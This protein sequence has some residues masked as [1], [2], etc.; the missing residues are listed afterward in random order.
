MLMRRTPIRSRRRFAAVEPFGQH[1]R[2]RFL[3]AERLVERAR[4]GVLPPHQQ[5]QLRH[6]GGTQPVLGCGHHDAAQALALAGGVDRDVVDPAAMA[7]MTDHRGRDDRAGVAANQHGRTRSAPCQRDV[8]S[9]IVPRPRQAAGLPQRDDAS[10]VC[11]G[12]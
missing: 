1:Y 10:D 3:I 2:G 5:L 8:G 4:L 12:D 6:A 9:G 7:V 11:I